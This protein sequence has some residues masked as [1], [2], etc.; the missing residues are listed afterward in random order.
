MASS[1]KR[2][3]M[4][5]AFQRNLT[6]LLD[7]IEDCLAKRRILPCLMLLYSGIDV[8]A[9][10]EA[11]RASR[12]AFTKWVNRYVLKSTSLS[13]T[14]SDL[15][16]ARCGILHTLSAESDMSR[17][18]QARQIVYAWGAAKA[19]DLALTSKGIGRT[20]CAIHIRELIDAF[21]SGLAD[22]LD[23]VMR[24]DNRQQRLYEGASLWLTHMDQ[25]TVKAFL[26]AHTT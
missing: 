6:E 8:I 20:D 17:K 16:G 14:A 10:L 5:T 1:A 23:E 3:G 4:I 15:Y 26:R 18:G 25:G 24:D 2:V 9:S 19:A 7:S 12:S 22:Y 11:G 13:C 21:R